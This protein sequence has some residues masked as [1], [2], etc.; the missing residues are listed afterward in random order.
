LRPRRG[1]GTAHGVPVCINPKQEIG[2][3][4]ESP[5]GDGRVERDDKN[6]RMYFYG[7]DQVMRPA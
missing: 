4:A 6:W 1:T 3:I 5:D 7:V 2:L